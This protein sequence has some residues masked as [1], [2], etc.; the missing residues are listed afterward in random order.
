MYVIRL[1]NAANSGVYV[2]RPGSKHSYTSQ[3][4]FAQI[5]ETEGEAERYRCPDSEIVVDVRTEMVRTEML[6]Y[7]DSRKVT[8]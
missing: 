1:I 3:L 7:R 6:A 8:S 5:F 2:A 4:Q